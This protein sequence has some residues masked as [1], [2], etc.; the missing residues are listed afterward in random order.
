MSNYSPSTD[1]AAKDGLVSGNPDKK[2]QGTE[3]QTEF[4]NLETHIGTKHDE[5]TF[6]TGGQAQAGISVT[7]VMSPYLTSFWGQ[8][9]AGIVDQ[10]RLL[11]DPGQD[12]V[13]MWDDSASEADAFTLA[14]PLQTSGTELQIAG[15]TTSNTG[16]VEIATPGEVENG[17]SATK[18]ASPYA[19]ANAENI[20]KHTV[21]IRT[22]STNISGDDT[23][24]SDAF[25]TITGLDDTKKYSLEVVLVHS[26]GGTG[27]NGLSF[28]FVMD[29]L[30]GY[31]TTQTRNGSNTYSQS[32]LPGVLD[33]NA[34]SLTLEPMRIEGIVWDTTEV[35]FQW[36]Q[37]T[38]S[39]TTSAIHAGSFMR[40]V[41]LG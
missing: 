25:L 6:A 39:G 9:N 32:T 7:T 22:G 11:T 17:S 35:T 28:D 1:F 8:S 12:A 38:S 37:N 20:P 18:A 41:E 34:G 19:L 29:A 14:A 26:Q 36:A 40:L 21:V 3:F 23:P 31:Y 5:D 30:S 2:V 24:N 33:S 13:L 27:P 4:D 10:L 15:A 16:V